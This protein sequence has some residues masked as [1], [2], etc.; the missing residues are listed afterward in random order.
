[1]RDGGFLVSARIDEFCSIDVPCSVQTQSEELTR[2]KVSVEKDR[3]WKESLAQYSPERRSFQ[4]IHHKE[5]A[6]Q[7]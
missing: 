6:W 2:V 1:M 4:G 5:H 7:A 3:E